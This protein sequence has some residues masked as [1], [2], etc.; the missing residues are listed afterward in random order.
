MRVLILN[1]AFYPDVVA[2]AQMATDLARALSDAGHN[3]TAVT[4]R[5]CYDIPSMVFQPAETWAGIQIYRCASSGLGKSSRLRRIVESLVFMAT[6]S[7]RLLM[8][9]RQD[10]VIA[11]TS[12]PLI[13]ILANLF[14]CVKG[15]SL[16]IWMMDMNPDEA[17]AA[18]W[19]RERS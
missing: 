8:I 5:R 15:G 11:M 12:P 18:G 17:I 16:R 14:V 4:G 1:Q 9:P 19:L 13:S 3:V 10:V 6:C 7:I 2:T